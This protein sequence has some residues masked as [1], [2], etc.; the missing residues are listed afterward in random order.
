MKPVSQIKPFE[1]EIIYLYTMKEWSINRIAKKFSVSPSSVN[2]LL[3]KSVGIRPAG[4]TPEQKEWI[5]TAFQTGYS[6]REIAKRM[7][8]DASNI[9]RILLNEFGI[10]PETK[11]NVS[12][13]ETL[14]PLFIQDYQNGLSASQIAKK[15]QTTH[16]TVLKHLRKQKESI[17]NI[18][19]VK[20]ASDLK[21]DYFDQLEPKKMR[22]LGQL[23]AIASVRDQGSQQLILTLETDRQHRFREIM[24]GW[25]DPTNRRVELNQTNSCSIK[26]G[27]VSLCQKLEQWGIKRQYPTCLRKREAVFWEG[28]LSLKAG[29]HKNSLYIGIPKGFED[30]FKEELK[31]FLISLGVQ[32]EAIRLQPRSVAIFQ[33]K[34]NRKLVQQLPDLWKEVDTSTLNPYWQSV[35]TTK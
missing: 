8:T 20:R 19:E 31:D 6:R 7:G 33:K 12:P 30:S 3:R 10:Q 11:N 18:E 23:W 32:S 29:F 22:Q 35:L 25:A 4:M 21:V 17:L 13:F 1:S 24:D 27:S 5:Y 26:I 34:E 2:R 16:N 14:I 9:S 28:Y 15:Y